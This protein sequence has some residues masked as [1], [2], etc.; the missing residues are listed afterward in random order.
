MTDRDK[1]LQKTNGGFDVFVHYMG[2][3]CSKKVFRNPFREDTSPSCSIHLRKGCDRFYLKDFGDDSWS[4]DC[5]RFVAML[6]GLDVKND[7]VKILHIIDEELN[8][9]VLDDAPVSYQPTVKA[10]PTVEPPKESR[11]ISF[12]PKYRNFN[13]YE[14]AYWQKYG[15]AL[16]ILLRYHVRSLSSCSFERTDGTSFTINS[17]KDIPMFCYLLNSGTGI[18]VYRPG[19]QIGRFLYAGNLPYPYIFGLNQLD[20][21]IPKPS[22]PFLDKEQFHKSVLFITGGEKD[23]LSLAAHGFNAICFSSESVKTPLALIKKLVDVYTLIVFLYDVDEP[24]KRY[25]ALR[26]AE[27]EHLYDVSSFIY[28]KPVINVTLPLS[29]TKHEKDVSDFFCIGHTASELLKL[30]LSSINNTH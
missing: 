24:G 9:F 15:I 11:I 27:C 4:G 26:V 29:G 18:K 21:S 17:S 2:E 13:K 6:N 20:L 19:V 8:L 14:L 3:C 16:D 1:I 23:V 22:Y 12:T 28:W 5:F 25:S 30:V 10:V 7:F